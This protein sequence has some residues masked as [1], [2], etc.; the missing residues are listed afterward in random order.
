MPTSHFLVGGATIILIDLLLAGDNALVIAMAV[1]NLPQRERR[2]GSICGAALAV[3]LRIAL[4]VVAAAVLEVEFVKLAGGLLVLWIAFKVLIDADDPPESAPS[5]NSLW[6][7]VWY[8]MFA[9]L[10]MSLDNILAIAGAANGH[11]GL[12]IFGLALSIPFVVFSSSLL[13]KLMDRYPV[14]IYIGAAIL[15]RVGGEMAMTDPFVERELHP[16]ALAKYAAEAALI[17]VVVGSGRWIC[18][19]RACARGPKHPAV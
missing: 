6:K 12:I 4:T 14:T 11:I 3:A 2:I 10:T 9:D 13:S 16:S 7:A 15:A 8:V 1:R 5:S 18:Y 17:V 19:R